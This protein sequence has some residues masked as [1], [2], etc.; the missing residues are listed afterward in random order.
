MRQPTPVRLQTRANLAAAVLKVAA[1]PV[2]FRR[3]DR[4]DGPAAIAL[5]K[6]RIGGNKHGRSDRYKHYAFRDHNM[7]SEVA[8]RL[9]KAEGSRSLKRDLSLV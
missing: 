3:A 9:C 1:I 5:G 4:P 7:S 6:R 8:K 2:D